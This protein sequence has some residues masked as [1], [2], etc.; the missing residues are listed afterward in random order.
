MM[1]RVGSLFAVLDNNTE[2]LHNIISQMCRPCRTYHARRR[3]CVG[4]L[5]MSENQHKKRRTSDDI[6]AHL[7]SKNTGRHLLWVKK[8]SAHQD[9]VKHSKM[10][11][12]LS[13][14]QF[15]LNRPKLSHGSVCTECPVETFGQSKIHPVPCERSLR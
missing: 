9:R 13:C 10:S 3:R 1:E 11:Q 2:L 6:I 8:R 12:N 14:Y 4:V 7:S 5:I 15:H